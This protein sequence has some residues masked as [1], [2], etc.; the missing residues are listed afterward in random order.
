VQILE[1]KKMYRFCSSCGKKT[2]KLKNEAKLFIFIDLWT[3][4][5]FQERFVPMCSKF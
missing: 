2:N 5:A 3:P 4:E 1:V